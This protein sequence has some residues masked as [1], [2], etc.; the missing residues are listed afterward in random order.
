VRFTAFV[1]QFVS[2]AAMLALT[3]LYAGR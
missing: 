2:M 1:A 3:A